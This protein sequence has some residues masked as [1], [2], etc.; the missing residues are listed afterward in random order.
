MLIY[1]TFFVLIIQSGDW[2]YIKNKGDPENFPDRPQW[3]SYF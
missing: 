3:S 2:P 1:I